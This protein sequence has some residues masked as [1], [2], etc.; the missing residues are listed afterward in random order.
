LGRFDRD[1][2]SQPNVSYV[3]VLEGINDIGIGSSAFSDFRFENGKFSASGTAVT[4]D[5]LIAAYKQ[6]IVRAHALGIK[7]IGGTL[8]PFNGSFYFSDERERVRLNVNSWIRSSNA[9]DA[10][11]DFEQAVRDKA[12]PSR[13][14]EAYDSGDKL[15][16]SD[17][18][19][20]A[21]ANAID[22]KLFAGALQAEVRASSI[23]RLGRSGSG[24]K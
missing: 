22:L 24:L 11:I 4:S 10:V 20:A 7:M 16:P 6:L 3:I 19:Y 9:F 8:L 12:D 2:A 14:A 15:H 18:G 17:A 1:V 21:M 5:E 13:L 23:N